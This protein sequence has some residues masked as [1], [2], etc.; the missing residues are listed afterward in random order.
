MRSKILDE[1]LANFIA[2]EAC[3]QMVHYYMVDQ[4][5]REERLCLYLARQKKGCAWIRV[6]FSATTVI[7]ILCAELKSASEN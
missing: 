7:L 2:D 1:T 4:W 6:K 3:K 5:P